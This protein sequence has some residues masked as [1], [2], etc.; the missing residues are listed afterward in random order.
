M[1]YEINKITYPSVTQIT[2]QLDKSDALIPWAIK[3]CCEYI[4]RNYDD[5]T[6]IDNLLKKAKKEYREIS[7]KA[8]DI[9]TQ[10]HDMIECYIKKQK[11]DDTNITNEAHNGFK[12]FLK[13]EQKNVKKWLESEIPIVHEKI[14]YAGTMDAVAILNDNK[15]YCID[16]KSS[17]GFY[18]GYD[19]QV[20]AYKYA[21]E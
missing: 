10:V 2:G 7:K 16:F 13:W 8:K 9:G 1:S 11:I 3:S 5:N 12:A 17:K 19:L 6:N 15:K 18:D 21:R 20:A 14:C 4:H